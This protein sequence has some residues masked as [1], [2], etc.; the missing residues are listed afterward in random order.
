MLMFELISSLCP[1]SPSVPRVWDSR[2]T[3]S[4]RMASDSSYWPRWSKAL[5]SSAQR[6]IALRNQEDD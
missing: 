5:P 6:L 1:S 4:I 2:Y 3:K